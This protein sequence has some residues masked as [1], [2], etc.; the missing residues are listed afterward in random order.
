[1]GSKRQIY[2]Q[3]N[4]V[5]N[6]YMEKYSTINAASLAKIL[7]AD[8]ELPHVSEHAIVC[9]ISRKR[10]AKKAAICRNPNRQRPPAPGTANRSP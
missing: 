5:I 2:A 7:H 6:E 9:N 10:A 1:M 8:G 3:E 4:A